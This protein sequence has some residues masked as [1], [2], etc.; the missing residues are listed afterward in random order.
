MTALP[1][2][3]VSDSCAI[4]AIFCAY[5]NNQLCW[6]SLSVFDSQVES[7]IGGVEDGEADERRSHVVEAKP[8]VDVVVGAQ[9]VRREIGHYVQFG[10]A[11]FY[12]KDTA[13]TD[14]W[15]LVAAGD[16]RSHRRDQV[17]AGIRPQSSP[18]HH[19]NHRSLPAFADEKIAQQAEIDRFLLRQVAL[20]VLVNLQKDRK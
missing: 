12:Q 20:T 7:G 15:R 1:K 2:K 9:R 16:R 10:G 3:A 19:L 17:A 11:I 6:H 4:K 14:R 13:E 8:A 18:R 5:C